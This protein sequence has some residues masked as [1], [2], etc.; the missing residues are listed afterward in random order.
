MSEAAEKVV[1]ASPQRRQKAR[2]KGDVPVST[3][4]NTAA[5]YLGFLIAMLIVAPF[6]TS[7]VLSLRGY[8]LRPEAAGLALIEG[9]LAAETLQQATFFVLP[10]VALPAAAVIASLFAQQGIVIAPSRIAPDIK[11]ISPIDGAGKK[12]GPQGL[13]EFAK[14]AGK[15]I[16]YSII[17][18]I[19]LWREAT[20]M[21][22]SAG[23]QAGSLANLLLREIVVMFGVALLIQA[24]FALIDIP[25]IRAQR[26]GRIKMSAQEAKD[27]AKENEGD[28]DIK[29]RRR[30][31]AEKIAMSRMMDDTKS[32]DVLITN[33]THYA[34]ALK[35]ERSGDHLPI[36][37]AKGT[38]DVAFRLREVARE[39]GVPIKEDPPCARSLYAT[40]D[41]GA[42]IK[43]EHF[44][45]VAA[46]IRFADRMRLK[47]RGKA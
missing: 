5:A 20:G 33:P 13:T 42:P 29:Q 21:L 19:I 28:Q 11:K 2:G 24:V 41:L 25:L 31:R 44:A 27:E 15:M 43:P 18:G 6:V 14:S 34:V 23:A 16:L 45:A 26:E 47:R 4:A 40:V 3:E 30:M 7:L 46:A 32:A 38:D 9:D 36:C 12:F 22:Q 10:L 8:L 35:W 37:V 1:E 39:A 17:G